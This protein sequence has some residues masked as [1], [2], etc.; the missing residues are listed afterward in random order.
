MKKIILIGD[1][2]CFGYQEYVVNAFKGVADVIYPKV[3]SAFAENLL[4]FVNIWKDECHLPEDADI[5]HFNVGLWDVLRIYGDDVLTPPEF[6]EQLLSR[7][8]K[9]LKILFPKAKLIFATSTAVIEEDYEPPY[10]RYNRDII[11]LNDIAKRVLTPLGVT[12]D[13]LYAATAVL[14]KG[15]ER[16]SDMT[17]FSSKAGVKYMGRKVTERL[18]DALGI[19]VDELNAVNEFAAE[20]SEQFIRN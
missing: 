17:H 16:R 10:Q 19:S 9:R 5:V 8:V 1:S 14:P 2:I 6:Y 18:C 7:I 4:R 11:V 12:F 3:N 15:D 20:E 13:E